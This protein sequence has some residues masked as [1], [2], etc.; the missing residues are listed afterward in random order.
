MDTSEKEK[1]KM[2]LLAE[3]GAIN[4]QLAE[5]TTEN[6][7]IKGD[8]LSRFHKTDPSD[9]Q[10]DKA[11][12]VT[13]FEEDRAVEQNMELRKKELEEALSNLDEGNYGICEKC[14]SPIDSRRLKVLPVARLCFDCASKGRLI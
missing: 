14:V 9:S 2:S 4:K 3:L 5:F 12:S 8:R 6:P 1:L 7:L 13:E 10:S 11:H